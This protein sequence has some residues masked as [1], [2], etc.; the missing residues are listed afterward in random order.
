MTSDGDLDAALI[1]GCLPCTADVYTT[2][3][4]LPPYGTYLSAVVDYPHMVGIY[5]P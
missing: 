3:S 5:P 4:P 1:H 2:D